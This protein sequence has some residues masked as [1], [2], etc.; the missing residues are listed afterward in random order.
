MKYRLW[1]LIIGLL[2]SMASAAVK[3]VPTGI[4]IDSGAMGKQIFRYPI[5]TPKSGKGILPKIK[6][7]DDARA[8]ITYWADEAPII[9]LTRTGDTV[10]GSM[11]TKSAGRIRWEMRIP[12]T[13]AGT[14]FFTIGDKGEKKP[15][16]KT[17]SEKPILAGLNSNTCSLFDGNSNCSILIRVNPGAYWQLQD[18]RAWKWKIFELRL[19]HNVYANRQAQKFSLQFDAKLPKVVKVRVD[20]FGQPMDLDF[21]GK[22]KSEQEL[23]ADL[24]VDKAYYNSLT[25]PTRS[26][27]GGLRGSREKFGL[28]AT[29][30]F[31][32]DKIEGRDVLV[33]PEGDVFFQ[34]GACAVSP[35]DDYTYIKGR[36]HIYAWLPKYESEYKSAFRDSRANDFSFYLANR[37]RKY[38]K[39]FDL[40]IWKSEQI[41]RLHKWG[42]N[43]EG[44]FTR[45]TAVN[46]EK[47]FGRTPSLYRPKGLIGSIC[48]PF[49][50]VIREDMDKNFS[51]I[52]ADK[53][54][55][56]IIGYFISNE[57]PYP[58][59]A[60]LVPGFDGK[61]AAKRELVNMLKK[62]YSSIDK[63]NKAWGQNVTEFDALNELPLPVQTHE[64]WVD[65][66][67]YAAHFF[68]EYFKLVGETFRKY[69]P[70]H[71]LI[72]TRFLVANVNV[73]SAVIACGKYCDVFSYNYYTRTID[74]ALLER[75]HRLAGKPILLSEWSFGTAE[76][77]LAGGVI[78]VR[79]QVERGN[80]YRSYVEEAAALPYVIGSQWFSVLDQALTGRWFQHY[81]G[82]SMNI[83]L[84]NV[85]DRPFKEFLAEIMKTN[86]QIYD[87]MFG[88][89]KPFIWRPSGAVGE[90]ATKSVQIPHA[91]SGHKVDGVREPWPNRPSE[92]IDSS[93]LV[94]GAN[95]GGTSADF[96]LC[97]DQT[98]LYLFAEVRDSTPARNS[99]EGK[100]LWQSDCVE[101][102]I[103]SEELSKNG[104]LLFS[105]RQIL[106][107]AG[108]PNHGIWV[109][110][111]QK[112]PTGARVVV[113][114]NAKGYALEAAISW[115]IL[116]VTPESGRK[117]RL[118]IGLDDGN[119]GPNRIRQFMWSGKAGNNAERTTWGS[120]TLVD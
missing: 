88:K 54:D 33:T 65:M 8:E 44:A 118:D 83:G 19:E 45:W 103:G 22:I 35:C 66:E 57:Q 90:R 1:L 73:E 55:S 25:P 62:K 59:V 85:A 41:D 24:A 75:V 72:G 105:D 86:Y 40:E 68:E 96:W 18:N 82:E 46:Q 38:G 95:D 27:W 67:A 84:V 32:T 37:I 100:N 109:M 104:P 117:I 77:G 101:L 91:A 61:V 120:A 42:F 56:T 58:D 10:T 112:Q 30:F 69:D 63:F 94:L 114:P 92:R 11:T 48:D 106:I 2:C 102:F 3:L 111:R 99:R 80:A 107:S 9:L 12:I 71:L 31:R 97:W 52:A 36:E 21:S 87:V 81:N 60:R 13:F 115:K 43:S 110:N 64:A 53:D 28:K 5:F 89:V 4:E 23:K 79:N 7:I 98:Y 74:S 76:Q 47:K 26:P 16:P 70:N 108:R 34:L 15:F 39:P 51:K 14:G 78:D 6:F 50:P 17:L 113:I 93:C 29:G 116:G 119:D 20:R 49:D